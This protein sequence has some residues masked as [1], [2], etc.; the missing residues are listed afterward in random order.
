MRVLPYV[1][2]WA[3]VSAGT[4]VCMQHN[5]KQRV[6]VQREKATAGHFVLLCPAIAHATT[7]LAR[8]QHNQAARPSAEEA[9]ARAAREAEAL[10][11]LRISANPDLAGR[12]A[13]SVRAAHQGEGWAGVQAICAFAPATFTAILASKVGLAWAVSVASTGSRGQM[14]GPAG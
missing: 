11:T 5:Q 7:T 6:L 4:P 9:A 2:H 1:C 10:R 13:P 8:T 12:P 14:K 3:P